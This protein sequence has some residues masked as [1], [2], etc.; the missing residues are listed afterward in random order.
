MYTGM[1]ACRMGS[2]TLSFNLHEGALLGLA[3]LCSAEIIEFGDAM[4]KFNSVISD[5]ET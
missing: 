4:S 1:K 3:Q 5:H 2:I